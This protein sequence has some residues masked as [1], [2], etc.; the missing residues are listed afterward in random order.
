MSEITPKVT[1]GKWVVSSYCKT[2]LSAIGK[3]F[4]RVYQGYGIHGSMD[5]F[6]WKIA[7]NIIRPGVIN[8]VRTPTGI[9]S[10]TSLTPKLLFIK[11]KKVLAAEIGDTFTDQAYQRQGLFTMLV[12]QTRVDGNGLGIDFIYGTPND[13][14]LPGYEKH[15]N[16]KPI[17]LINVHAL[18][19]PV[20]VQMALQARLPWI[21]ASTAGFLWTLFVQLWL[22]AKTLIDSRLSWRIEEVRALPDDWDFFWD[23]VRSNN[24]FLLS[25]EREYLNW[26]YFD[27][28]Y[29]YHVLIARRNGKIH[30]YL[31]YRL[32]MDERMPTL[33]IADYLSTSGE[34]NVLGSLLTRAIKA[35]LEMGAVKV[36]AWCPSSN[37]HFRQF[38]AYGFKAGAEVPVICHQSAVA[39][40]IQQECQTW[41]FSLGDSDNV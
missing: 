28:P 23:E 2:D 36:S 9:G 12:N 35:A 3:F 37:L 20:H 40:K 38:C 17:T 33:R 31:V 39:R 8:L 24:D 22:W 27:N 13:Q 21:I 15:A 32:V 7:D 29:H 19:F 11:G 16:F 1:T 5:Y 30:G 4:S 26:R 6:Q 41:H 25:R 34:E 10:V 18:S 14:S